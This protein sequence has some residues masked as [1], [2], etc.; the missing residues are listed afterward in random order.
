MK[1][2]VVT[3]T[4][5]LAHALAPLVEARLQAGAGRVKAADR[6]LL[7][8]VEKVVAAINEIEQSRYTAGERPARQKLERAAI[9][10]RA[11]HRKWKE[12]K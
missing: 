10:L 5:E 3:T 4:I 8:G 12:R 11:R 6:D 1:P 7:D 2:D 9:T